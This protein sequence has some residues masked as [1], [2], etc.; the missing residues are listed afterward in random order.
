MLQIRNEIG[1]INKRNFDLVQEWVAVDIAYRAEHPDQ[2]NAQ[3]LDELD[4][5]LK[6]KNIE[7]E[8]WR[9]NTQ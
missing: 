5:K 9:L 1:I 6:A 7:V 8:K 4:S 3:T 2:F